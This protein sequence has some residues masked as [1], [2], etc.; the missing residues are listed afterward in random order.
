MYSISLSVKKLFGL[1]KYLLISLFIVIRLAKLTKSQITQSKFLSKKKK[2]GTVFFNLISK[3][4]L[5][6]QVSRLWM[7]I[8]Q[9][10]TL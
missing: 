2:Y 1:N 10:L 4:L 5:L 7:K 8:G 3:I 9:S 6:G